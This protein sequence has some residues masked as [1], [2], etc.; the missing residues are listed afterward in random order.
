MKQAVNFFRGS[1]RVTID[2]PYPERLVNLCA[3]NDIEFWDFA[4]AGRRR[5][6]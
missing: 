1:V 4:R 2:C 5:C 3:M 6:A